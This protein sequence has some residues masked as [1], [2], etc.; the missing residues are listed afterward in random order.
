MSD[1]KR[2]EKDKLPKDVRQMTGEEVMRKV[3]NKKVVTEL[4]KAA[5]PPKSTDS[6]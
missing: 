4:K 2:R 5:D 3:F 6:K 1:T